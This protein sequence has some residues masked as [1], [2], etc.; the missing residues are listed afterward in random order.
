MAWQCKHIRASCCVRRLLDTLLGDL[1]RFFFIVR[2]QE[3]KLGH[4]IYYFP[5]NLLIIILI[6]FLFEHTHTHTQACLNQ[7]ILYALSFDTINL[8]YDT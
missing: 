3:K 2:A 7:R 1:N 8:C 5:K 6:L 4:I